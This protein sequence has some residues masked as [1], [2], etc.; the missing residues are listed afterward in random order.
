MTGVL[1]GVALVWGGKVGA[2]AFDKLAA[3]GLLSLSVAA[4]L[5]VCLRTGGTGSGAFL[6]RASEAA[7][8]ANSPELGVFTVVAG[9]LARKGVLADGVF[10]RIPDG[11]FA[12]R[13]VFAGVTGGL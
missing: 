4:V 6:A 3:V 9:L 13:G 1:V 8:G 11:V 12:R 7:V 10:G 2:L 5:K